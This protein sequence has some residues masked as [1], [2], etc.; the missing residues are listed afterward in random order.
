MLSEKQQ[1]E[2]LLPAT[3]NSE[4]P[5]PP[6]FQEACKTVLSLALNPIVG[7]F[8]HP[9][10]S[11]VNAAVLGHAKDSTELAGLGLGSLTLG[12][13]V[14]S[15]TSTFVAGSAT[16]ISQA[17]GAKDYRLCY[18][19]RNRQIFLSVCVYLLFCIPMAFIEQIY[20]L[21]GQDPA[22]AKFATTYVRYVMPSLLFFVVAQTFAIFAYNQRVTWIPLAATVTGAASH[23]VL[24]YLFYYLLDWG[25]DGICLA[26]ALMFVIRCSINCGAVLFS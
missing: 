18:I 2:P 21:L 6:T 15:I 19:Y 11:I 24:V 10:Y 23:A 25:F 5:K 3:E 1:K 22:V 20:G 26:T 9:V 12:I 14:I 7:S 13:C 17:F 4:I 16:L 8:F